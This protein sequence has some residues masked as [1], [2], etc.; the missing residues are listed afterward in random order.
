M[1]TIQL[2]REYGFI[3]P[4]IIYGIYYVLDRSHLKG[5]KPW[6]YFQKLRIWNYVEKYFK[7]KITVEEDLNPSQLYI[8]AS[9]PHGACSAHHLLTMTDSCNMISKI[10]PSPRRD[11]AASVLFY[12]PIVKV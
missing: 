4:V 12:I 1:I 6:P 8:F 3:F 7:A 11:L 5:V 9:F 10:Y 2:L